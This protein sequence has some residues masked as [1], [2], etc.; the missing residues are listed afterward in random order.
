MKNILSELSII[1]L[2]AAAILGA[3]M[4]KA[5]VAGA[6]LVFGIAALV[7]AAIFVVSLVVNVSK[8]AH[9]AS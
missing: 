6:E 7:C 1:C 2:F 3:F 5:T 4:G 8:R 9:H